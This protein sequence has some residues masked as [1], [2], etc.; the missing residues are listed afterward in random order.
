MET[1]RRVFGPLE[2][3]L[4]SRSAA[5]NGAPAKLEPREFAALERLTRKPGEVVNGLALTVAL[6]PA[7]TEPLLP[8]V[9]QALHGLRRKIDPPRGPSFIGKEHGRGW[10]FARKAS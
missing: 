10:Y 3:D 2:I 9:S 4:D 1:G 7:A 5:V 8:V 6:I